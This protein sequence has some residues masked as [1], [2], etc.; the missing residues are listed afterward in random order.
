M[1]AF[2][3]VTLSVVLA[4]CGANRGQQTAV[5]G[6]S[7]LAIDAV[8]A[9]EAT[10]ARAITALRS[11]GQ[12]GLV[13]LLDAHRS[14]VTRLQSGASDGSELEQRVRH[15]IDLVAG[16]RDAHQSELFWHTD[17][18]AAKAE[19]VRRGIPILSLRLLGRL[20]EEYSC[21]NSRFFRVLLYPNE[22]VRAVLGNAYVLHWSSERPVPR[23]TIDFGNGRRIERTLTGNSVHYVLDETGRVVDALPGLYDADAFVAALIESHRTFNRCK[24]STSRNTCFKEE[25][26]IAADLVKRRFETLGTGAEWAAVRRAEFAG[27]PESSAAVAEAPQ[28]GAAPLVQTNANTAGNIAMAKA[29]VEFPL[30]QAVAPSTLPAPA[31]RVAWQDLANAPSSRYDERVLAL[32]T[33]KSRDASGSAALLAQM[34]RSARADGLRNSTIASG[35]IHEWLAETGPTE[36]DAINAR[37]YTELFMTPISDPW[38]GLRSGPMFDALETVNN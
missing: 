29:I 13:Q 28:V 38:L 21:A 25:H 37:M 7:S 11:L 22:Q 8:S 12:P 4:S 1:R 14:A 36:F 3:I 30:L 17:I 24:E 16:Q 33:L 6:S 9:D 10:R 5:Q 26:A 19:A 15:A 35:I 32:V 34:E 23:I 20:D 2:G 18:E 27:A 31:T